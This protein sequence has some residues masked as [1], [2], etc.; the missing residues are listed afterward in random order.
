ME[1]QE[2]IHLIE[3]R[4]KLKPRQKGDY[5]CVVPNCNKASVPDKVL[6]D[7]YKTKGKMQYAVIDMYG[8]YK[9]HKI[10]VE[11]DENQHKTYPCD[12]LRMVKIF[13]S[14][15]D[16]SNFILIRINPDEFISNGEKIDSMFERDDTGRIQPNTCFD[17]R[18]EM[19]NNIINKTLLH[20]TSTQQN[21]IIFINYDSDSKVI[22]DYKELA[23]VSCYTIC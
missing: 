22:E 16:D 1:I 15:T 21:E 4:E 12:F 23:H 3:E 18:I 8:Y 6:V 10:I 7:K 5:H 13:K 19:I 17:K 9:R 11:I 14:F 2:L 20:I